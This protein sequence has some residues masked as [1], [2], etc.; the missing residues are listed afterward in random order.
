[1]PGTM[2][3]NRSTELRNGDKAAVAAAAAANILVT[4]AAQKHLALAVK[5]P[6]LWAQPQPDRVREQESES[7]RDIATA[8]SQMAEQIAAD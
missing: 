5:P 2:A 3:K 4:G 1:M 7:E 6:N 8:D